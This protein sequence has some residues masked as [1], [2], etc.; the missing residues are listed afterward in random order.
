MRREPPCVVAIGAV[1]WDVFS[2]GERLGGAP[3]NFAVHAAALGARSAMVSCVGDDA[4]GKIALEILSGRGVGTD[5]VQV[6]A[7]RP[8]GSV[9]V[10]F[11]DGQPAYEIVEGVA[12]DA[13]TWCS[14]LAPIARSAHAL[15]FGT[16]DQRDAQ[17]RRTITNFLDAVP[18]DCLRVLDVNFRQHYHTD[19]IVRESIAR[20]DV[21]KLNDEEVVLLRDYVGG[22]EDVDAFL[23]DICVRFDLQ[24][25]ILT[26]GEYGCR[27]VSEGGIWQ[28]VGKRQQVV[29]TV[30]A[31]DAF[32][33]A[34]VMHLLAG[35]P[36]Q[37]CAE[38]A[39]AVGGF[40]T[41]QD[42]GMP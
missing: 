9:N 28:A 26:L 23:T 12:W 41:T 22:E 42:G 11:V 5:A 16:L 37:I 10:T 6:H 1:L 18:P 20:A 13:I 36:M 38:Q 27:I 39:N 4:R 29:N 19:E 30:G 34:F 14:E 8:T 25:V 3:A 21:L 32:T 2:D 15:C 17:S 7:H 24:C 35:A 40:V 31:G 33:A